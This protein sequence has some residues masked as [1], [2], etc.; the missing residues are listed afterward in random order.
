MLKAV[1][2]NLPITDKGKRISKSM[3]LL[4]FLYSGTLRKEQL[5]VADI[6]QSSEISTEIV[7]IQ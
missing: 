2:G 3:P 6:P 1:T 7:K 4:I 5:V